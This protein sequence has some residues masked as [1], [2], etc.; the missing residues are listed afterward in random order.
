MPDATELEAKIKQLEQ[1]NRVL[2]E[3]LEHSDITCQ[4]LEETTL[5]K[6]SLLQQVIQDFKESQEIL[7]IKSDELEQ[8][9]ISLKKSQSQLI[10]TEK[11]SS[12]GQLVAGVA[13]EINNP[14]NFIHG[15]LSHLQEYTEV[16]MTM[17]ELYQEYYPNPV[18]QIEE[19]AENLDLEFVQEDL[20]KIVSSIA[21]GVSRIREI[22]LSLRNFS[23]LDEFEF[24][25]VDIHQGIDSTLLILQHRLKARP[26][27][28]GIKI[29]KNYGD[30]PEV[31]CYPGQLNQVFMNILANGI[32]ALEEVLLQRSQSELE[33]NPLQITI[34]TAVVDP[35]WVQIAIADNGTGIPEEL[36]K[37]IFDL[38]FTT[39]PV[40]KGTGIGMSI[41]SQIITEKHGGEVKCYSQF[42]QGTEFVIKIPIKQANS[43][44]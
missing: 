8:A 16:L 32:D 24:K 41:C 2:R 28:P 31:E 18:P 25:K 21:I 11:M 20:P 37:H 15:N 17:M 4:Q 43:D 44:F 29:V 10:Q 33:A 1:E 19:E 38:F 34:T 39:K 40:G 12:L 26:D 36:S 42:G 7:E 14:V 30:L 9:L 23:R 22:V 3:K 27:H 13:H 5:N 6:E 35:E